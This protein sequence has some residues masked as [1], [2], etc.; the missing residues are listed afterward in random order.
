[1][2]IPRGPSV[3]L[4]PES[5]RKLGKLW[6]RLQQVPADTTSRPLIGAQDNSDNNGGGSRGNLLGDVIGS[7]AATVVQKL[8]GYAIARTPPAAGQALVWD[9]VG[10]AWTPGAPGSP[11]GQVIDFSTLVNE[12]LTG[13]GAS[14]TASS[15][16]VRGT[17]TYS[18]SLAIDNDDGTWHNTET[19]A[20]PAPAA[21]M[22]GQWLRV[23]LGS[24]KTITYYRWYGAGGREWKLQSSVLGDGSDW[25]DRHTGTASGLATVDTGPIDLGGPVTA[26]Y[27]RYLV[28]LAPLASGLNTYKPLTTYTLALYSGV[29]LLQAPGHLI[30]DEGT[31]ALQRASLNFVG[32]GVTV[33][34]DGAGQRT[35]V[36]IPGPDVYATD[37][38]LAAAVA[39]LIA[40]G[41]IDA[42]GDLIVGTAADTPSRLP[43]GMDGQ[44]LTADAASPAGVKWA[45]STGSGIRYEPL[46]NGNPA[47]PELVFDATG[48]VIMV[49]VA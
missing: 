39:L 3:N 7:L 6:M 4:S 24:A 32:Q 49:P 33:T 35:T 36:T 47:A 12:A 28:T 40:R 11:T 13:S 38:E 22:L 34:D 5:R 26:R 15:T 48:D 43:V 9:A 41:L 2:N 44:V 14:A 8:Q 30:Q 18:P 20:F 27:W 31:P 42:K 16:M 23:D 46:T 17:F 21:S 45:G 19:G 10:E 29:P 37:V 25:I 1:M